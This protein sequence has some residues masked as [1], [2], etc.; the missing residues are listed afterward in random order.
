MRCWPSSLPSKANMKFPRLTTRDL[1]LVKSRENVFLSHRFEL[2]KSSN[3][4][5]CR[6]IGTLQL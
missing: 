3:P 1:G 2:G 5:F 6:R 4:K